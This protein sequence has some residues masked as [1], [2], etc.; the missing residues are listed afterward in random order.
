M[1]AGVS[2]ARIPAGSMQVTEVAT[3]SGSLLGGRVRYAQPRDGFRSGIEP[4]LLA[5]AVPTRPGERVLEGGSGAGAALLCLAARVPGIRG[6]G[7]EL[8]PNLAALA[9]EN[10]TANSAEAVSFVAADLITLSQPGVFDH[11]MANPPYHDAAGTASDHPARELAKRGQPGLLRD[12]A[13]SLAAPLRHRGTLT[14][15]LPTAS[16]PEALH[17]MCTAGCGPTAVLPLWPMPGRRAK[18]VLLRGVKGGRAPLRLL[19]GLVLHA[20]S[21]E[22]T[23]EAEAVLRDGAAIQL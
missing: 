18:L 20:T 10:A 1:V 16:L 14:L 3:S 7:V 17:A 11:A 4:V 21:G 2:P 22:F 9:R 6:L 8:D 13:A 12:W 23:P 5:A 19:T 15:I